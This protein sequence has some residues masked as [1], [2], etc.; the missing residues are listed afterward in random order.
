MFENIHEL[1]AM[2]VEGEVSGFTVTSSLTPVTQGFSVGGNPECAELRLANVQ[3]M[4]A[5][6]VEETLD[7]YT[8]TARMYG[9]AIVGGLVHEGDLYLD[10]PTIYVDGDEAERVARERGEL[11][12]FDLYSLTEHFVG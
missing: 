2:I 12:Y 8:R 4:P 6:L 7:F 11:A 5:A 1:A 3:Q 10:A 9:Q